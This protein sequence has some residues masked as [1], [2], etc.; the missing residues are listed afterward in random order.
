MLAYQ[1]GTELTMTESKLAPMIGVFSP[2]LLAHT[3]AAGLASTLLCKEAAQ[4]P[5]HQEDS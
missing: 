4:T 2:H 3:Y 1:P 5:Q